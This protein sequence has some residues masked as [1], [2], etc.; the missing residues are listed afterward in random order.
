VVQDATPHKGGLI[1]KFDAISD[2]TAAEQWGQRYLLVPMDELT[3]PDDNELFMHDLL[4]MAVREKNGAPIGEVTGL[5]ELPQGLTLE[6][7]TAK[8]DVLVPY[9]LTIVVEVDLDTRTVIVDAE[10][11]LFE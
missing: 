3:P 5:Y 10:S 4:G 2:R 11:G 1:V 6:V 7:R 8:G 9:R